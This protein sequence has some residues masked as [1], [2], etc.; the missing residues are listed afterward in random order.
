VRALRA[1]AYMQTR[2]SIKLRG[3]A[4]TTTTTATMM[5]TAVVVGWWGGGDGGDGVV[6]VVVVAVAVT[7]PATTAEV[8]VVVVVYYRCCCCYWW[9]WWW[10]WTKWA[11]E[12]GVLILKTRVCLTTVCRFLS[13]PRHFTRG[14][15]ATSIGL[16]PS[17]A[18]LVSMP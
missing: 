8:V 15:A 3:A 18:A 5:T 6:A 4:T 2:R 9:W 7:V 1:V 14:R 13:F 10:W 11:G 16:Y 17:F 12:G